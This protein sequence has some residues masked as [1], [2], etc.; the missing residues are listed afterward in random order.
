M[1]TYLSA[2]N[3]WMPFDDIAERGREIGSEC[4]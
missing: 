2:G 4:R 1:K 3:L